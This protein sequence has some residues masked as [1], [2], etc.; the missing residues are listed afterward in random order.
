MVE[1]R[2]KRRWWADRMLKEL[3][4]IHWLEP[5]EEVARGQTLQE[6]EN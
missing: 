4:T 5:V 6:H 2:A 3:K 1:K